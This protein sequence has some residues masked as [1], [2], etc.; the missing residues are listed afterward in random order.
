MK[1]DFVTISVII[2]VSVLLV[3]IYFEEY[4]FGLNNLI[5]LLALGLV[6]FA[7]FKQRRNEKG[8]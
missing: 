8:K 4:L 3:D 6:I 7:F 2:G 1:F 5:L